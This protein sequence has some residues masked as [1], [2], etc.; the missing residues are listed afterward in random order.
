MFLIYQRTEVMGRIQR[1][2]GTPVTQ[3]RNH[4][5][6]QWLLNALLYDEAGIRR[7]VL[8]HI[9]ERGIDNMLCD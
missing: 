5:F 8:T 2:T 7:T 4:T 1:V 3:M 6:Q 9:P